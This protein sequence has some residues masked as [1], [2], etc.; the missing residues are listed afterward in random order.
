MITFPKGKLPILHG[1][2]TQ[3]WGWTELSIEDG[4]VYATFD[5][6]NKQLKHWMDELHK[7]WLLPEGKMRRV[8]G[9]TDICRPMD[10][11][12]FSTA[13]I[14][15]VVFG[16]DRHADGFKSISEQIDEQIVERVLLSEDD[17]DE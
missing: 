7:F 4:V 3:P 17:I 5:T 6:K 2:S 1:V 13:H 12:D 10:G 8:D 9:I 16:M 11:H 15:R 14:E